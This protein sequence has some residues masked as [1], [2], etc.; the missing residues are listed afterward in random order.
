VNN[1]HVS[2]LTDAGANLGIPGFD[3]DVRFNNPGIP[4]INITGFT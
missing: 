3:G 1:C 2:G 4:D